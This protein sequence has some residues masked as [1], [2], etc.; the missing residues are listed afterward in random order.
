MEFVPKKIDLAFKKQIQDLKKKRDAGF[1]KKKQ[2][3]S[4]SGIQKKRN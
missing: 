3:L 1:I 2:N 4:G